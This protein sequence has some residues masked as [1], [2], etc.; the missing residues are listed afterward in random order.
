MNSGLFVLPSRIFLG[1]GSLFF[2]ETQHGVR[3]PCVVVRDRARFFEK[4]IF[5]PT[6]GKMDQ[7]AKTRVF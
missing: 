2:S 4:N 1:I 6:M 5:A 3:G 7:L